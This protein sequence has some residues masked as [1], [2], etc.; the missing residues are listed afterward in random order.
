M[1]KKTT[2][3]EI[4]MQP[5]VRAVAK[6]GSYNKEARTVEV[7]AA[8]EY[9]VQRYTYDE[10]KR[11]FIDF[12]EIL[13]FK[14]EHFRT[15]R[16][17]QGVVTLLDNHDRWNG[18]KGVRGVIEGYE[19]TNNTLQTTVRFGKRAEAQEIADDVED[20]ILKGFSLGYR[21]FE[22]TPDGTKGENGLPNWRATDWEPLELSVAPVPADPRSTS[23]SEERKENKETKHTAFVVREVEETPPAKVVT[24]PAPKKEKETPQRSVATNKHTMKNSTELKQ[25]RDE[26]T[27]LLT[28][29][30]G[31]S[32]R[33]TEQETEMDTLAG[34]V[35]G[36]DKQIEAREQREAVL[37]ANA[38]IVDPATSADGETREVN[39]AVKGADFGRAFVAMADGR[40]LEGALAEIDQEGKRSSLDGGGANTF[41]YPTAWLGTRAGGADDFQAGSGDG[42]GFV[43]T[44]VPKFIEALMAPTVIETLGATQLNGLVGTIQFPRE[45]AAATA[46]AATEVAAGADAGL[47]IDQWTMTPKRYSSKTT[48][49]KQLML[50]SPLAAE[51][52]IANAL[53]RGHDRKLNYD[54]FSGGGSAAITG[55]MTYSGV[56]A[57]TIA[58]GTDY[59][60]ICAALRKAVL[61]D[62]GD[63]SASKFAISPLTDEFFGSAVNVT[64]VDAL[65]RDGKIKGSEFMATPYLADSTAIL[66][67]IVYGDFSNILFGNWGSL[68]FLVDPYTSAN[69]AQIVIHLNRWVD[70]LAQNPEAFARYTQVGLT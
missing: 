49:S 22:Y 58:D 32:E 19:L 17:E 65:I 68:D 25:L 53:R 52:I 23:R 47:E 35:K 18:A 45:S 66:G 43:P 64:G 33:S 28:T 59:E 56:N 31:Q 37:A 1:S 67:Q 60:Q 20:G 11:D 13:S 6:I 10:K 4:E 7:T 38:R 12:N 21:V 9:A 41:S 55:L 46:T 24:I 48:Y 51:T 57:P 70:M 30:D 42:S 36:L 14:P 26:K 5:Q 8:T 15:E 16:L 29:L 27:R 61:E 62:H 54:M 44:V 40:K 34:E 3:E 50:Q 63:L 39:K 2:R 69:T